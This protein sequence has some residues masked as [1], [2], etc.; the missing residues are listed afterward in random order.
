MQVGEYEVIEHTETVNPERFVV[1]KREDGQLLKRAF[2]LGKRGGFLTWDAAV[3]AAKGAAGHQVPFM[4]EI[5]R[6]LE[7]Q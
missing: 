3:A 4:D 5:E 7:Q 6:A 2:W 1:F